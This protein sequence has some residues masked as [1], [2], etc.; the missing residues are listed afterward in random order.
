[1]RSG[2]NSFYAAWRVGSG[3]VP[4]LRD[5]G[6]MPPER[7][8][9]AAWHHQRLRREELRTTD[10]RRVRVLH[11]GFWN[12]EGGPDFRGALIQFEDGA[13]QSGDVEVDLRASGWQA[14]RH[15]VNPAFRGVILH[16]LWEGDAAAGGPPALAL[17][18]FLDAPLGELSLWLGVDG[19]EAPAKEFRGKCCAPLGRLK[20][21]AVKD[22]LHQAADVRC[23]SKGAQLQ[24]RARQAG[25]EQALWEGLFRGLGYKHNAWAMQRVA[26]LRPRWAAGGEPLV[27]QARVLGL[28]GL[29]PDELSRTHPGED[30]YLRRV[31]DAWWRERDEFQ[32]CLLPR[33]AWRFHGLRPANHPER[34]L[35]LG[36]QWAAGGKLARA[37]EAWCEAAIPRGSLHQSLLEVLKGEADDFWSWHWTMR[38]AC[39]RRPQPLLGATRVTDLAVNVVLPWLWIRAAEGGS[40]ELASRIRQRYYDWPAG[41]DNAVLRLARERLLGSRD[42]RLGG[43]AAQQGLIQMVR[44]FCDHSNSIC[45]GCKL[46]GLVEAYGVQ[47]GAGAL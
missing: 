22:L 40:G 12:R 24:A 43:A 26:E 27:V 42:A 46:P 2:L 10:G 18:E 21:G 23:H 44:D 7:L 13:P 45:D 37:L 47:P 25:W 20:A 14:H 19:G 39:L 29:L 11:P 33:K 34:R 9:Q 3:A 28:S 41:E 15:A 4:V 36:A 16:V 8:L 1:M 35:A 17:K 5:R 32:D 31:W 38:S 6:D 30:S